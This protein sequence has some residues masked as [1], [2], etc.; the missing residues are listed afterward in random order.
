MCVVYE[1]LVNMPFAI[2]LNVWVTQFNGKED[3]WQ[4]LV[5][6]K[7]RPLAAEKS[8]LSNIE[9]CGNIYVLIA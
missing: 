8:I 4:G 6:S 5:M 7:N 9:Q 1:L 2:K 3:V